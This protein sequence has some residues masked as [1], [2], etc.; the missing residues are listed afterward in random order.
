MCNEKFVAAVDLI[1]ELKM[2]NLIT[3]QD[4]SFFYMRFSF[5]GSFTMR[6]KGAGTYCVAQQEY[7]RAFVLHAT[8]K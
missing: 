2:C 4:S 8:R 1:F 3:F 5:W 6:I 7:L